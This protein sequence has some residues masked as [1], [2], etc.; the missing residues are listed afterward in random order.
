M[1]PFRSFVLE[2]SPKPNVMHENVLRTIDFLDLV[3]ISDRCTSA[4]RSLSDKYGVQYCNKAGHPL[5]FPCTVEVR[6]MES[7]GR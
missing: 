2:C 1:P 7:V 4:Y 6:V 5:G 3:E